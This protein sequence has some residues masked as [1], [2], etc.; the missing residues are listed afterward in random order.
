MKVVDGHRLC[1]DFVVSARRLDLGYG[2]RR[3]WAGSNCLEYVAD[4][5]EI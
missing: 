1:F 3:S 2:K 4:R 5:D